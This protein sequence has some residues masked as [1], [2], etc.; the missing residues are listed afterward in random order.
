MKVSVIIP[1]YNSEN[2][3]RF[4]IESALSQTFKPHEIIVINDCSEDDTLGVVCS[5]GNKINLINIERN[6]GVSHARN[7]GILTAKG[8]F[9]AF[10]DAD[11]LWDKTKLE[12]QLKAFD[13][14][15]K[16]GMVFTNFRICDKNFKNIYSNGIKVKYPIFADYKYK[17]RDILHNQ[18]NIAF[19][20][21]NES[22]RFDIFWGNADKHLLMGN[23]INTS[24]VILK[25]NSINNS[26]MFN[27]N[28][29]SQE[30]YDFWIKLSRK[31]SFA[32]IDRAL[33]TWNR[34]EGNLTRL[35]QRVS[36][37]IPSIDIVQNNRSHLIQHFGIKTANTRL[38]N[39]YVVLSKI[40]LSNFEGKS[41]RVY[42]KKALSLNPFSIYCLFLYLFS[43]L[44]SYCNQLFY[45]IF[46][47][48]KNH[49]NTLWK[50]SLRK[51]K[52]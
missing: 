3:I 49:M 21:N 39:M 15:S 18:S 34:H 13:I 48:T 50:S 52:H 11:D 30:D 12:T 4:A 26:M 1:A 20:I 29:L 23:F 38:Y 46:L 17:I 16:I 9:L 14:N 5:Y 27:E 47:Y 42:I 28:L 19:N 40:Y 7:V 31:T 2:H 51:V 37:L 25:K 6:R 43:F 36:I 33:V 8:D 24:S 32:Y 35:S 45:N 10:L 41:S 22:H 44:P